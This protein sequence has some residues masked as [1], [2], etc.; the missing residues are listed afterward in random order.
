M[1]VSVLLIDN[2]DSFTF[3]LVEA[4]RSIG[5]Q[6]LKV[7][8][9]NEIYLTDIQLFDKILIS[10]GPGLPEEAGELMQFLQNEGKE[11]DILGICLG[12]QAIVNAFG[13]NLIN[14]NEVRHGRQTKIE[15]IDRDEKLFNG[16][17]TPF[18]A[19]LY[20][21]WAASIADF[22]QELQITAID[23]DNII[24]AVKH[25]NLKLRAVQFHPESYMTP[26]GRKM[27]KNWVKMS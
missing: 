2:Y 24:M 8:K 26:E 27:L 14:L 6:D 21:S 12:L 13:G 10:P 16:I 3:N 25:K 9:N 19:G 18:K 11:C 22:P 7:I 23:P 15:I 5:V 20:H 17:Q 1:S 4:L